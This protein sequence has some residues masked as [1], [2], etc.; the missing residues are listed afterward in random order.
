[1]SKIEVKDDKKNSLLNL[2]KKGPTAPKFA[3]T[4]NK[5]NVKQTTRYVSPKT[6]RGQSR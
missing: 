3:P 1:M 5:G 4:G 2:F 6:S